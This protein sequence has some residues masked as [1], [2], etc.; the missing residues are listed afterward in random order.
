M[1]NQNRNTYVSTNFITEYTR[2]DCQKLNKFRRKWKIFKEGKRNTKRGIGLGFIVQSK[3]RESLLICNSSRKDILGIKDLF[4]S[5]L[6]CW[7]Q[8]GICRRILPAIHTNKQTNE[9]T[10][11]PLK[12]S[13]SDRFEMTNLAFWFPHYS[14][15]RYTI[16][17]ELVTHNYN[18][19]RRW[20]GSY[21]FDSARPHKIESGTFA[22][23]EAMN[24]LVEF[25]LHMSIILSNFRPPIIIFYRIHILKILLLNYM[26]YM[27]LTIILIFMSIRYYL[28]FD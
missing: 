28:P 16:A 24:I 5:D 7:F 25:T 14:Q 15:S 19:Q 18:L 2:I 22:R 13:D 6:G 17:A 26:F 8:V 3:Q 11:D 9:T 23:L 1:C 4:G 27:F 12:R 21:R 10:F 20:H